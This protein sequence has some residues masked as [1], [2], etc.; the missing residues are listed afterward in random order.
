[1]LEAG[2]RKSRVFVALFAA[3]AV[4]ISGVFGNS[5]VLQAYRLSN[6]RYE[7]GQRIKALES[8]KALLES[9]LSALERDP[10]AQVRAIRETL[11]FVRENELVFEFR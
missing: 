5:G 3:W 10:L 4:W 1:M 2:R 9:A 6:A 11:G 7:L 8:E